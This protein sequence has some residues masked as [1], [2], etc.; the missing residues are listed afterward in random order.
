RCSQLSQKSTF[1]SQEVNEDQLN[2]PHIESL[3]SSQIHPISIYNITAF[4]NQS[5][6]NNFVAFD[7]FTN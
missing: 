4:V 7:T 6:L 3:T 5:Y 1:Y 2:E